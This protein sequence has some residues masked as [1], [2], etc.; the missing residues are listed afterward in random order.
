MAAG[1][2][3]FGYRTP[4]CPT[5][6]RAHIMDVVHH[7]TA[8]ETLSA[9]ALVW[10][11]PTLLSLL[12]RSYESLTGARAGSPPPPPS[13]DRHL[14][15]GTLTGLCRLRSR[16]PVGAPAQPMPAPG[17]RA[18]PEVLFEVLRASWASE[19]SIGTSSYTSRGLQCADIIGCRLNRT[20]RVSDA[21]SQIM[22]KQK[23]LNKIAEDPRFQKIFKL[24]CEKVQIEY[25]LRTAGLPD[26][27]PSHSIKALP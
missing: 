18:L 12:S 17:E 24:F 19:K 20:L 22:G 11:R 16:A 8:A 9:I 14:R 3:P 6:T 13:L 26:F 10:P 4:L 2:L 15:M 25:S 7:I 5:P 1:A 21:A 27:N 23:Q